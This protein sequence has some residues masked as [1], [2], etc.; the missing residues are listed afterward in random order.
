MAQRPHRTG[1]GR[2]I[3]VPSSGTDDGDAQVNLDYSG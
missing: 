3:L 1:D 2:F